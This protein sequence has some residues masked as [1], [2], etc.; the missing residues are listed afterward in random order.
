MSKKKNSLKIP[1]KDVLKTYNIESKGV[2]LDLL[3]QIPLVTSYRN[4][5]KRWGFTLGKTQRIISKFENDELISIKIINSTLNIDM[6]G[7][8]EK[9]TIKPKNKE[10][11]IP[12]DAFWNLYNKKEG[13]AKSKEKWQSLTNKDREL[14]MKHLPIYLS[15]IKDKQYQKHPTTYLNQKVWLDMETKLITNKEDSNTTIINNKKYEK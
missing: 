3:L 12:F 7:K 4:I 9:V 1:L 6:F 15:R 14:I 2:F 8:F 13:L 10:I 5:A 11:N